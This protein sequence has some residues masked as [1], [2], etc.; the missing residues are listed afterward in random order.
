MASVVAT[1]VLRYSLLAIRRFQSYF[2]NL[3]IM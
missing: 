1:N 2:G 3:P